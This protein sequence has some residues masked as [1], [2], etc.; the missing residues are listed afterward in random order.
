MFQAGLTSARTQRLSQGFTL[1]ELLVVIVII[2]VLSAVALPS[3]L[4]QVRRSR[5]V[6][7]ESATAVA[8]GALTVA[9]LDCGTYVLTLVEL[10]TGNS[11]CAG[12]N[13]ATGWLETS[14]AVMAPNYAPL[15]IVPNPT[16]TGASLQ[17]SGSPGTPYAGIVCDRGVGD[18]PTVG[19]P[20]N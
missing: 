8:A 19:N 16:D 10:E 17:T 18:Q 1:I 12:S 6:E 13:A 5:V 9:S 4:Q 11:S 14:W 3:F 20:C 15:V 7:G 2:G